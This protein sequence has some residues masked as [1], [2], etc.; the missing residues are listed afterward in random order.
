MTDLLAAGGTDAVAVVLVGDELL[1][2]SVADTNTAWLARTLTS[3]GLRLTSVETVPDDV[4]RIAAAIRRHLGEVGSVVVAGGI[5][6]TS[7]DL[8]REALAEVGGCPLVEDEP[9][10]RA[11]VSAMSRFGRQV[12]PQVLRMARRPSRATMIVNPAGSAP[13]VRLDQGSTVVYA[14]PGVPAELR[15]MMDVLLPEMVSRAGSLAP[16][17]SASIEVALL[18]ESSVA[19]MLGDVE[20]AIARDPST[21][22]AYLAR[23][24]RVSVRVSV[25]STDEAA[26][27]RLATWLGQIS[28]ALGDHVLGPEGTT[29]PDVVVSLLIRRAE[30]VAAAESLTGGSVIRELTSVPGCSAVVRGGVTAYAT[31]LK[32]V[33]LGVP[34]GLLDER[35]PVAPDVAAAMATGVRTAL[36]A[37]WGLATTGVAG[38]DPVGSHPPGEVHLAVAGPDGVQTRSLHLPGDRSRVR[39]LASAGVLDGVRRLLQG[40]EWP[41]SRGR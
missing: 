36:G 3:R 30:T 39:T 9:A 1:L 2:G 24:A 32:H 25:R 6:P 11:I 4:D 7:D 13:G 12:N 40:R 33:L 22:L 38:P 17:R 37:T 15:S 28:D 35:G 27:R 31:D 23:P 29:L 34:S 14:T 16:L 18:G 26:D 5:G 20:A 21:D 41:A 10:A 19:A 8:T